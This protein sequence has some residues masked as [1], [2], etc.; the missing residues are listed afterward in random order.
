MFCANCYNEIAAGTAYYRHQR[1]D[2]GFCS[3]DCLNDYQIY[4]HMITIERSEG[5]ESEMDEGD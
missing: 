3:L 1:T 2:Q 5:E 4:S